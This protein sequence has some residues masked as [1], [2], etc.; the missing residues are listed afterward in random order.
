MCG[1]EGGGTELS[2]G[3]GFGVVHVI[4]A[5]GACVTSFVHLWWLFIVTCPGEVQST[6]SPGARHRVRCQDGVQ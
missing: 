4:G 2:K 5:L 1:W 3:S 6:W